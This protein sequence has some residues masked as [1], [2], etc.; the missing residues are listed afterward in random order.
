M[1]EAEAKAKEIARKHDRARRLVKK[2]FEKWREAGFGWWKIHVE[3]DYDRDKKYR[4]TV[5]RCECSW[6]YRDATLTFYLPALCWLK[7]EEIEDA[8]IHELSH[9]LVA[10]LE[11]YS[12]DEAG[13]ITEATVTQVALALQF[14]SK[15]VKEPKKK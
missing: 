5:G 4:D 14:A 1:N 10:P 3:Y 2:Y 12:S 15:Y 8:V 9:I 7:E 13:Q 6:Q 11:D